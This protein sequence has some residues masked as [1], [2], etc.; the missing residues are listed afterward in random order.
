MAN[1]K[2]AKAAASLTENPVVQLAGHILLGSAVSLGG[3]LGGTFISAAA[4]TIGYTPLVIAG[5]P[6]TLGIIVGSI[7]FA[8]YV[9][10]QLLFG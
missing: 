5:S 10:Y 2:Q 8:G 6:A 7:T 1:D 9:G 4:Q 3:F